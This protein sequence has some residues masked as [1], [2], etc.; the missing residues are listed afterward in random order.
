LLGVLIGLGALQAA[1]AADMPTKA[2][3]LVAPMNWTGWYIGAN[4]GGAWGRSDTDSPISGVCTVASCFVPSAV[5]DINAQ[6]SQ[7]L[8]MSAFTGGVQAGYNHQFGNIVLG[9]EADF[10][11]F[12]LSGSNSISQPF[13]G[14]PTSEPIY[15]NSA[16]TNWL[17]TGRGRLG[18]AVNNWLIY[19]TGGAAVTKLSY[20]HTFNELTIP[21][22]ETSSASATK[23]GYAVGGGLEYA[24][25]RNWTVK[26]EYLY[27]DFGSITSTGRVTSTAFGTLGNVFSHSADLTANIARLGLNYHF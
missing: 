10:N 22:A 7:T 17:F 12:R 3:A 14:F 11:S 15:T 6:R 5:D 20:T 16:S 8:S 25:T 1:S 18:Y 26:A 23:V 24:L 13:T 4:A 9:A 19:A 21:D 2:P 27:L